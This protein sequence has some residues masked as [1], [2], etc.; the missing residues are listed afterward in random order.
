[1]FNNSKDYEDLESF[2]L[3]IK[4]QG[5]DIENFLKILKCVYTANLIPYKPEIMK[6]SF[7]P[8]LN[9]ETLKMLE[10]YELIKEGEPWNSEK[11]KTPLVYYKSI[12]DLGRR[13][14][15]QAFLKHIKENAIEIENQIKK[16]SKKLIYVTILSS[17]EKGNYLRYELKPLTIDGLIPDVIL[18]ESFEIMLEIARK[19]KKLR[20][21]AEYLQEYDLIDKINRTHIIFAKSISQYKECATHIKKFFNILCD[22][23]LAVLKTHTRGLSFLGEEYKAPPETT[24][25]LMEKVHDVK[26]DEEIEM[27]GLLSILIKSFRYK[28]FS[29]REAKRILNNFNIPEEKF[30]KLLD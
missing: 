9:E 20:K 14:G 28:D 25:L 18:I 8:P 27:F 21:P 12:T 17:I 10:N 16:F 29:K 3:K 2:L 26:I 19:W 23:G 1:M 7:T 4:S 30:I 22:L 6:G 5:I 11:S 24:Y 13:L 15:S